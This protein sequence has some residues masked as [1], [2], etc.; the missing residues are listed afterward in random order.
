VPQV[1]LIS[2]QLIRFL[3]TKLDGLTASRRSQVMHHGD[4]NIIDTNMP[5]LFYIHYSKNDLLSQHEIETLTNVRKIGI[6]VCLVM[7]SDNPQMILALPKNEI[8]QNHFDVKIIRKNKGY[9]LAAYRDAFYLIKSNSNE[10]EKPIFFMNN[11][12][13]WFP[14][15]IGSYFKSL[16]TGDQDIVASSISNQYRRHIQTFLFGALTIEGMNQID[17]WFKLIKNWRL[18]RTIV[19]LGEIKTHFVFKSNVKVIDVPGLS[20]VQELSLKKIHDRFHSP[21]TGTNKFTI[22]RLVGNRNL[23]FQGI[24]TNPSHA[25]WLERL[26]LGFPGT[27]ISLFNVFESLCQER[28]D[29]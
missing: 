7:N 24:P 26:E 5:L 10:I 4:L 3:L 25:Y 11:S 18:K 27:I 14:G 15:M 6:Q 13:F 16:L 9:D 1:I 22:D 20:E 8:Q 19:A 12:L 28:L 23:L 21:D 2:T 29:G 17:S